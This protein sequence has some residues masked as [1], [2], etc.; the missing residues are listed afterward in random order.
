MREEKQQSAN[1][2]T[3]HKDTKTR[4]KTKNTNGIKIEKTNHKGAKNTKKDKKEKSAN[5]SQESDA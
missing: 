4:R 1:R 2:K 5:E 3:N